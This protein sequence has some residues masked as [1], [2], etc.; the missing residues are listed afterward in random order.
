MESAAGA[1]VTVGENKHRKP[2]QGFSLEKNKK[3]KT[4]PLHVNLVIKAN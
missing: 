4:Y 3:K 2:L 1:G